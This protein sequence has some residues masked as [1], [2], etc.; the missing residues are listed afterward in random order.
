MTCIIGI[1]E[2]GKVY[3]G[4]DSAG[5]SGMDVTI[6]K[7]DKVFRV[8]DFVIGGTTS[9]R[10]LQLLKYSF[11]PPKV[12]G[13]LHKYMCTDFVDEIRKTFAA[14]GFLEKDRDSDVG[15][16]FLVAYKGRLFEI[17]SDFQ[18]G[19]AKEGIA[20]VG[21]GARYAIGAAYALN[22]L[23]AKPIIKEALRI[24]AH[25]SGGV[26]PPFKVIKSK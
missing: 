26:R 13:D 11:K 9:F 16:T 12:K 7:D 14:G 10:M 4:G 3:I 2:K 15:G 21:C 6:R 19:E 18:V 20:A 25:Y 5:V 22:G 23:G 17:N 1:V 24:S 8:G